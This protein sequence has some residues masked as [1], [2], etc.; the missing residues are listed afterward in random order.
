M[1]KQSK[2]SA[3]LKAGRLLRSV[4]PVQTGATSPRSACNSPRDRRRV[5]IRP[6]D[7]D[8]RSGDPS[9]TI[10]PSV[11][12]GNSGRSVGFSV[13]DLSKKGDAGNNA[14]SSSVLVRKGDAGRHSS[15]SSGLVVSMPNIPTGCSPDRRNPFP[16]TLFNTTAPSNPDNASQASASISRPELIV[17]ASVQTESDKELLDSPVPRHDNSEELRQLQERL[18]MLEAQMAPSGIAASGSAYRSPSRRPRSPGGFVEVL[19]PRRSFSP[20]S[21]LRGKR[22]TVER[23]SPMVKRLRRSPDRLSRRSVFA[24]LGSGLSPDREFT[25]RE[26]SPEPSDPV[27]VNWSALVDLGLLL[28]GRAPQI[29]H[30][31]PKS[32]GG[33]L[34]LEPRSQP[35]ALS[36]PPS[37]GVINSL[38]RAFER[39]SMGRNMEEVTIDQ[40]PGDISTKPPVSKFAAGFNVR[41]HG[42]SDF[43][44]SAKS[45][46]PNAEEQSYLRPGAD[47][48]VPIGKVADVE[49]LLR[50]MV[51][52][53]S[54][55]DWLLSTLKEIH[56][57]PQQ[58]PTVLDSLW[59][60]ITQVFGYS[61]DMLSGA[62]TSTVI[63]R[64]EAFLRACDTLKAPK[65][66]HTWATLRP[67]FRSTS[68]LNDA[69]EVL[70]HTSKEDREAAF[71]RSV[72]N[73]SERARGY[74]P[75]GSN[76]SAS[77][78]GDF[79]RAR[80]NRGR[81]NSSARSQSFRPRGSRSSRSRGRGYKSQ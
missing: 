36:F 73:R 77:N 75:R 3:T 22:R 74:Q 40:M 27:D 38:T 35:S 56:S 78:A 5:R 23:A 60:S 10:R 51:R 72:S 41:F 29:P 46:A 34:P 54:S 70:R 59:S 53:M 28:A 37:E 39:F 9:P 49:V 7:A 80:G 62:V 71:M 43:P 15:P 55:L 31:S 48:A 30:A 67:L 58:D 76:N 65:R 81:G 45:A 2:I 17:S 12:S 16:S 32:G 47:P 26:D 79:P 8:L 66:T 61:T 4:C 18:A 63:M 50:R 25:P 52:C 13:T 64:R 14:S 1:D 6:Q 69:S 57:L 19:T 21:S 68:L 42:G 20:R 44:L 24:R 11:I 33:L